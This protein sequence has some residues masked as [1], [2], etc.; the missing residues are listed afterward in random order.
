MDDLIMRAA[1]VAKKAHFGQKR[2]DGEPYINHPM[3][4]AGTVTLCEQSNAN[5][6]AAAWL[7]DVIEDTD[8]TIDD[9]YDEFP[10]VVVSWVMQLTDVYTKEAYPNLNRAER[11]QSEAHS[12]AGCDYWVHNIKLADRYDNIRKMLK[13]GRGMKWAKRY[14]Q[15][16]LELV[17]AL[18]NGDQ[19][20][21]T[22]VLGR[23][24]KVSESL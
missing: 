4:V 6:V 5:M 20:L 8:V 1:R 13:A 10:I 14:I 21:R 22:L 24:K 23:A 2:Y 9:L 11:K 17:E 16:T 15:E 3:R 12:L 7:H 19:Q 18:E